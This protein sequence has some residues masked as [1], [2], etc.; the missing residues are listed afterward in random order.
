MARYKSHV[1]VADIS[2][3]YSSLSSDENNEDLDEKEAQVR[4]M[5]S[6]SSY[7]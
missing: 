4:Q 3:E 6:Y 1:A 5:I 2:D 7:L